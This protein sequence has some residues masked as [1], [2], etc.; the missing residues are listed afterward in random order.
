MAN[1]KSQSVPLILSSAGEFPGSGGADWRVIRGDCLKVLP[2]L[3]DKS[4]N[5]IFADP[6]Y[7]LQLKGELWRPNM[8]RVDGVEDDWDK[9][10]SFSEYDEFCEAW[11][12]ECRRIL[13]DDGTIWVIGSYHNIGRLSRLMQDIGFWTLNDVIWRKTNP[14]PNF[15]GVRFTNATETLLW[16][17]KSEKSRYT[18]NHA[19]M[20]L[21]NGGKQM[22]N[23]WEFPLCGGE[24]RLRDATGKKIHS[25]QKP[26]ALLRR[27]ILCSTRPGDTVLDPFL[28]SGTTVAAA[29]RAGRIGVGIERETRYIK[30]AE[31]RIAAA[32]QDEI[33][34]DL[35]VKT[36]PKKERRVAFQELL[37]TGKIRAGSKLYAKKGGVAAKVLANGDLKVNGF[38]GSIHRV[39]ARVA[40]VPSCNGWNFWFVKNGTGD[41]TPLDDLRQQAR[42][43]KRQPE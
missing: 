34:M 20:K 38:S 9:F 7:N 5:L 42:K 33:M 28:G 17:K 8:T 21:E 19:M 16:A 36:T 12:Q 41:L 37:S 11:L 39:G 23:V 18:F 32:Q 27:V 14:M 31:Q 30:A 6:P 15:R 43:E 26:E 40:G 2:Q 35:E 3:P 13:T 10:S 24:E 4:V 1:T 22:T 29:R 25:T